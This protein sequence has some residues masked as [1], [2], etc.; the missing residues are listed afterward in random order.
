M[1]S[2]AEFERQFTQWKSFW[3]SRKDLD[4]LN[5]DST[6]KSD[7][8]HNLRVASYRI[9]LGN[10]ALFALCKQ[11]CFH[12][13]DIRKDLEKQ[14]LKLGELER[15]SK[16]VRSQRTD[17]KAAHEKLDVLKEELAAL[18]KDY[19]KRRPLNKEDVEQLVL[20][21]TEQPKFIEKQ[22]EALL[23]DVSKLVISVKREVSQVQEMLNLMRG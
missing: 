7:F 3:D 23:E 22:T 10:K 21:I 1:T 14:D 9:D 2:L 5:I 6:S 15:L 13:L 12:S 20:Q 11:N 19:L 18:R 4:Y 17:L 16:V 8:A